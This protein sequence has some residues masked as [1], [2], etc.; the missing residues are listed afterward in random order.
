MI[1]KVFGADDSQCKE[2]E[3]LI[4]EAAESSGRTN[5]NIEIVADT[6]EIKQGGVRS[7]PAISVDGVIVCTGRVPTK[8]EVMNWLAVPDSN[9]QV[10]EICGCGCAQNLSAKC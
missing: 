8:H 9:V 2:T 10:G 7:I 1:I 4:R 3:Q 5:V 6:Y